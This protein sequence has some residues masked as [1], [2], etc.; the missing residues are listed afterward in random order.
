MD[1]RYTPENETGEGLRVLVRPNRSLS[2]RAMALLFAGIAAFVITIG[3]GFSLVGAWLV[4]PFAGLEVSVVG[5]VLYLLF[6]HADD[7]D[8][9]IIY[10]DRITVV[11][12]QG[13]REQHEEFPR[14][15]TKVRLQ[16][17]W[18][19]YP[20]RLSIGSHGRFVAIGTG[21]S[22]EERRALGARLNEIL[23]RT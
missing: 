4:L 2:L 5:A 15:W 7:H 19:W 17:G 11:R 20:S 8:M 10:H 6:R 9:V 16:R 21:I 12:R 22:E 14:Y 18:S 1:T 13:G 23:R 3:I